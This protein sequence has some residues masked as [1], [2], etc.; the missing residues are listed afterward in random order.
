MIN[1]EPSEGS[2]PV[3]TAIVITPTRNPPILQSTVSSIQQS[4]VTSTLQ[5]SVLATPGLATEPAVLMTSS[6]KETPVP[7][8]STFIQA[9]PTTSDVLPSST[10]SASEKFKE[11][12]FNSC[13]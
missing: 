11:G 7:N 3:Y 13:L 6:I 10:V 4:P 9:S 8:T 2:I 12:R 1:P 5:S